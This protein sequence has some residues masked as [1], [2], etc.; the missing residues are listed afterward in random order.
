[1]SLDGISIMNNLI[2]TTPTRPMV[3]SI[4]EVEV[5]TGTYSAQYGAYMGVHINMVT[6][7]AAPTRSMAHWWSSS[8][9]RC[10]MR[11][12]SSPCRLRRTRQRPSLRCGR[13]SSATR[14]TGRSTSRN[15][16]TARTR[17]SSWRRTKATGWCSSQPSLSHRNAGGFLHRQF[18]VGAG[19]Q[20]YG[21]RDQGSAERQ[22]AVPRQHHPDV[23]HLAHRGQAAAVLPGDEPAGLW[24]A[25]YSVPVPTTISTNQTVD[26]I[27][28]NIGDKIRL[29]VRAHYQN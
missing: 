12:T 14:W 17:P 26:R 2:T 29:Y 4:Q 24:P 6:Q 22:H 23:A 8:A 19:V 3:E 9:T 20:H 15:F 1:M 27:D 25:T 10:W 28:Q 21:R 5:Q 13:T 7:V 11:G 18:L 16:I